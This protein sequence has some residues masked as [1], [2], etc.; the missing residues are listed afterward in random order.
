MTADAWIR[1]FNPALD[2]PTRLVCLPHAGGSA[3]YYLNIAKAL[4]P[5]VDVIAV[6]YPGRQDRRNERFAETVQEMADKLMIA[7]RPWTDRPVTLFG[8]SMGASIGYELALRLEKAGTAPTALFASARRAP[9]ISADDGIHRLDDRGL[10]A[11][12]KRLGGVGTA[13]LDDP[14][15]L[16]MVMPAIRNDY[17]AAETYRCTPGETLTCPIFALTGDHD[18]KVTIDQARSW[19]DHTSGRFELR[20]F[21]GAHFYIDDNFP[22]VITELSTHIKEIR[23]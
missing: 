23:P 3:S 12:V 18:P 16:D 21:P 4:A 10:I 2:A 1:R 8:H 15:I 5:E 22:A 6:Q 13:L 11:E 14:D 7:L 19:S 17:R 9:G 20:V